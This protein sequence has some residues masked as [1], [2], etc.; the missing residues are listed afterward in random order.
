EGARA[1]AGGGR[2]ERLGGRA[3]RGDRRRAHLRRIDVRLLL[4]RR[5]RAAIERRVPRRE[6]RLEHGLRHR[7][8]GEAAVIG[9]TRVVELHENDE[10]GLLGGKEPDERG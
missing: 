3:C 9:T 10:L 4:A 7:G 1:L 8:G 6:R 5:E 2:G